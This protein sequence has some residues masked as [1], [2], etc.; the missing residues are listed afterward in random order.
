[1]AKL[2]II[3]GAGASHDFL[4]TRAPGEHSSDPLRD[5]RIPLADHLFENRSE[6]ASIASK[7]R[8]LLPILPE[9]RNRTGN[10]S[11]EAVL[12]ELR[13]LERADPYWPRRQRELTS[14]RFYLQQAIWSSEIAMLG[15]AAGLSNYTTLIGYVERF[16]RSQEPVVLITFNYDT[17]IERAL[18][19]HFDDFSYLRP[20]NLREVSSVTV[21][22]R[23]LRCESRLS[24]QGFHH[25][26]MSQRRTFRI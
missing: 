6:F 24:N 22:N 10:R 1:M 9:L 21:K 7:L 8:R 26:N 20:H 14:I 18:S 12:E 13:S 4:P 3:F 2:A 17:L 23:D 16:R 11:V 15:H 19:C 5:Y 25:G